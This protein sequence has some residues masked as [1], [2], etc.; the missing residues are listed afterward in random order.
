[1]NNHTGRSD[2]AKN[3]ITLVSGAGLAQLIA[4]LISPVLT[5]LFDPEQFASFALFTSF[6]GILGVIAAGRFEQ[7]IVL[8]ADDLDSKSIIVIC[9]RF[10]MITG[11]ITLFG[12]W[13]YDIWICKY[14]PSGKFNSWFYLLPV[15]VVVIALY[16]AF[17]YWSTRNKTFTRNSVARITASFVNAGSSTGF[18]LARF[19][20]G[21]IIS[22]VA[23]QFIALLLLATEWIKKRSVFFEGVDSERIKNNFR[24]YK[25]FA[26]VNTPHAFVDSLKENG[27]VFFLSYYFTESLVGL[28]NFAF[29]ILKAPL[30]LIGAAIYQVFYQQ[31]SQS[32]QQKSANIRQM[33]YKVYGRM[34]II[35]IGP[36]IILALYAPDIFSW[37]FGAKWRD[38]GVIAQ[39][40]TPWL[41]LNFIVSPVSC[42][43]LIYNRQ[44][45]AFLITSF[46]V[47]IRYSLLII[48]GVTQDYY[49]TFILLSGFGSCVMLFAIW[50]YI[51]II[52]ES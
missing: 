16:N 20:P 46:D 10:A 35:G 17:N 19:T 26:Y 13:I 37:V 7:A 33:V 9:F 4:I 30:G 15:A 39:I 23:G 27:V 11:L 2:F 22:F 1:M 5:R 48:G 34:F 40:L 43:P 8:P 49:F 29:R 51:H 14:W 44:R 24:R 18:G 42:L 52:R 28:Y 36:F 6:V 31:V 32:Y 47:V 3:V 38:A 12:V 50:W 21:L 45:G 41:F 25:D